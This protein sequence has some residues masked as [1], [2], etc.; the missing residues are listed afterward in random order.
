MLVAR[1]SALEVREAQLVEENQALSDLNHQLTKANTE[2]SQEV[3]RLQQ[4]VQHLSQLLAQAN[5]L[6]E[7]NGAAFAA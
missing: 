1:L 4:H 5:L 2:A 3:L 6:T 7:D